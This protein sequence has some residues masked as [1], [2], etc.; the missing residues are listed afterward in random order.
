MDGSMRFFLTALF[1]L[2]SLYGAG[3]AQSG[4]D[5]VFVV[6]KVPVQAT[7]ETATAAQRIALEQGRKQ[8]VD[9][10]LRRL[11][12]ESDWAYL[13][14]LGIGQQA[15]AGV[16]MSVEPN[17]GIGDG[18]SA[19]IEN[20]YYNFNAKTAVYLDGAQLPALEEGF[21]VL[22]EKSSRN[23]YSAKITYRFKADEIRSLLKRSRIPYSESQ[24]RTALVLPILE[25]VNGLYLWE[26]NNPWAR[27]WLARPL[28]NELTPILLPLGDAEDIDIISA[29][30]ARALNQVRLQRLADKYDV[31][32]IIIAHAYLSESGDQQRLR[33]RLMDGYLNSAGRIVSSVEAGNS[34]GLYDDAGG[35]GSVGSAIVGSATEQGQTLLET[36]FRDTTGDFPVLASR[37]VELTVAKYA[38]SWK[39]QTL[40]DHSISRAYEV[41]AW[42]SSIEEW[43]GIQKI[44]NE[45]PLVDKYDAEGLTASGATVSMRVSG[46]VEQLTVAL[47]Q[48]NIV[49]WTVDNIIWNIATTETYES[50][51]GRVRPV[52]YQ[53]TPFEGGKIQRDSSRPRTERSELGDNIPGGAGYYDP[54]GTAGD[55]SPVLDRERG[56][57]PAGTGE[58]GILNTLDPAGELLE[59]AP[60]QLLSPEGEQETIEDEPLDNVIY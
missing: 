6:S 37:A 22:D 49:F 35:Y 14:R 4:S 27:A 17:D 34:S 29:R 54:Q 60:Q 51:K 42:F 18:F 33:V 43:A 44:L 40:I 50:V 58:P 55:F 57:I 5:Q 46:D 10:L 41:N 59:G 13:P 7:A 36:F 20:S 32:Q 52:S 26:S 28:M 48:D 12:A 8:A 38:A 25:T 21:A 47:R 15:L 19:P 39:A 45:S 1:C 56:D 11:T 24:T 16:P 9:I 3:F 30:Q 23:T 2:V 31:T 53:R